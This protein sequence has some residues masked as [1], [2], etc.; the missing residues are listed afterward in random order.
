L[1]SLC[2]GIGLTAATGVGESPECSDEMERD[3]KE[4]R[5]ALPCRWDNP[6]IIE[7]T[8]VEG[9]ISKYSRV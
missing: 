7:V 6:K 5:L 2:I 4:F 3:D 1:S 8:Q 9:H